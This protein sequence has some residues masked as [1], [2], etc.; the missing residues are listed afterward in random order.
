VTISE[1]IGR[2]GVPRLLK[3]DT[4]GLDHQVV[5]TLNQPIEHI[6]FEVHAARVHDTEAA[7]Q[8]LDSL[9]N[10]EYQLTARH[11]WVFSSARGSAQILD[12]LASWDQTT[13]GNVYARLLDP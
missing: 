12:D 4:E 5:R 10:Y 3:I 8:H 1:L 7:L 2:Y 6:L 9:G 13:W 11:T